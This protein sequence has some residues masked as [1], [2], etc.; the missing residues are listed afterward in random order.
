MKMVD[1]K[2]YLQ[3]ILK[4]SKPNPD[5][6]PRSIPDA[7]TRVVM[8][9]AWQVVQYVRRGRIVAEKRSAMHRESKY[10]IEC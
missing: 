7:P 1:G 8:E 2:R 5:K 6:T 9:G 10:Y 4:L 3:K